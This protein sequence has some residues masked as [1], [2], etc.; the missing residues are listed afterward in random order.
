[1]INIE[2]FDEVGTAFKN[3]GGFY[4]IN[5]AFG[6]NLANIIN[7]LNNYLYDDGGNVA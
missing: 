6:G 4:K 7:E 3:A 2:T 5:K 1:M